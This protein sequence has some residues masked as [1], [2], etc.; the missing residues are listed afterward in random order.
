MPDTQQIGQLMSAID[1]IPGQ[2]REKV[3]EAIFL[4]SETKTHGEAP[5]IGDVADSMVEPQ[6]PHHPNGCSSQRRLAVV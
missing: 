6:M 5:V 1:E 2:R 3:K 4:R